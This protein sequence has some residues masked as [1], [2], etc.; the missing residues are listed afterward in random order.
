MGGPRYS[1]DRK[2]PDVNPFFDEHEFDITR[3]VAHCTLYM[4]LRT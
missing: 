1:I 2:Q 3:L 4:H